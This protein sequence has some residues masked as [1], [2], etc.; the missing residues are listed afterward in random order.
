MLT[1]TLTPCGENVKR[2]PSFG[3]NVSLKAST[4][5][6]ISGFM[7]KTKKNFSETLNIIIRQWDEFSVMIMKMQQDQDS[8]KNL[9]HF[10]EIKKAKAIDQVKGKVRIDPSPEKEKVKIIKKKPIKRVKK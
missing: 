6:T 3:K 8:Q 5:E 2:E 4:I 9:K 10:D 7:N 1:L